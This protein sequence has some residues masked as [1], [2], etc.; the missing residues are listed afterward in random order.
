M[1]KRRTRT[2][3]LT[4]R[5][6]EA[7][8]KGELPA[9][10]RLDE[11]SI[12]QRYGVSRTPVREALKQLA[13]LDLI[14]M[15]PHRG[16][17]VAGVQAV[18]MGEL[19]EALGEAEAVCARLAAAKMSVIERERLDEIHARCAEALAAGDQDLIPGANRAFHEAI[20]A[21]AHNAFLSDTVLVLRRKLA[22]FTTAQFRLTERPPESAREHLAVIRAIRARDGEAAEAAMRRHLQSVGRAWA[23]WSAEAAEAARQA[24]QAAALPAPEA[25]QAIAR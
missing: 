4:D 3:E 25:D 14:D 5:L 6:A 11:H 1:T 13:G 22:P 17:V 10:A 8:L 9:G 15:R 24:P 23:Q 12:A 21:G 19:F 20:Y 16:A 2:E 18:H 7:I